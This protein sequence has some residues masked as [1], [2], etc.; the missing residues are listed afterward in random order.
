MNAADDGDADKIRRQ[1]EL[2]K[3][4]ELLAKRLKHLSEERR[5]EYQK[6]V[7][8]MIEDHGEVSCGFKL[9][10]A[11][12]YL[13]SLPPNYEARQISDL[14]RQEQNR[15]YWDADRVRREQ[16]TAKLNGCDLPERDQTSQQ[17]PSMDQP[18]QGQPSPEQADPMRGMRPSALRRDYTELKKTHEQVAQ[19]MAAEAQT[20]TAPLSKEQLEDMSKRFAEARDAQKLKRSHAELNEIANLSRQHNKAHQK[21]D[22]VH[23]TETSTERSKQQRELVDHYYLAA[24][25]GIEGRWLGQNLR[26]NSLPGADGYEQDARRA[27]HTAHHLREQR[28]KRKADPAQD[29]ART[30]L[31]QDRQQQAQM[32]QEAQRSGRSITAGQRANAPEKA[33]QSGEQKKRAERARNGTGN[34]KGSHKGPT[35]PGNA[36]GDGRSR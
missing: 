31:E 8:I 16:L 34:E 17:K 22:G 25:M 32:Q 27:N 29:L 4:E 28:Q 13:Q 36:R 26:M 11:K 2:A 33:R 15:V 5:G 18:G 20:P 6:H 9:D 21:L 10:L 35:R 24:R 3:Q 30:V 14:K 23:G 1:E 19:R 7:D 12:T